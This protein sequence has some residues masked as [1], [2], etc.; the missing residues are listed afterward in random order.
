VYKHDIETSCQVAS[1]DNCI[2]PTIPEQDHLIWMDAKT[3]LQEVV[4][5]RQLC[6]D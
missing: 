5:A 6:R 4:M 1:V 3:Q 2:S